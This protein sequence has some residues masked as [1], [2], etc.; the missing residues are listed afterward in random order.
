MQ[1]SSTIESNVQNLNLAKLE[2][3]VSVDPMFHHVSKAFDAGGGRGL[4]MYTMPLADELMGYIFPLPASAESEK[5]EDADAAA[6][7]EDKPQQVSQ[8]AVFSC[9]FM[10]IDDISD[11]FIGRRRARRR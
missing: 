4:L 7:T 1:L 11:L 2:H 6:L 5:S 8:H 9:L 3:E 10:C